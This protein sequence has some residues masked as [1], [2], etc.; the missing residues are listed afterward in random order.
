[1]DE[2]KTEA[3]TMNLPRIKFL[4]NTKSKKVIL[5]AVGLQMALLN[6]AR[7]LWVVSMPQSVTLQVC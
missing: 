1:M 3:L 2:M 6:F 7:C 4:V 5:V